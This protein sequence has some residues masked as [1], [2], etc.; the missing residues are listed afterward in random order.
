MIKNIILVTFLFA[1]ISH[2]LLQPPDDGKF[3]YCGFRTDKL[4]DEDKYFVDVLFG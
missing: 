4:H 3:F 2:A 1:G